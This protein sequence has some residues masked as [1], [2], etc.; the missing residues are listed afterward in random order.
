MMQL[1]KKEYRRLCAKIEDIEK[2]VANLTVA[3]V[4]LKNGKA[5]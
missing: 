4:N 2:N 3:M 1:S 5:S